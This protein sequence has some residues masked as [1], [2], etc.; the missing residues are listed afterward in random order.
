MEE[1]AMSKKF[2]IGRQDGRP[3]DLKSPDLVLVGDRFI[4]EHL[5]MSPEWVRQQRFRRKRN[6]GHVLQLD[7]ILLG[8][9]PR[10]KLTEFIAWFEAQ[11]AANRDWR[12]S[13]GAS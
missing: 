2:R 6:L 10:Y 3:A 13:G 1:A 8:S 7:P 12:A 9:S 4:A 11:T 5:G